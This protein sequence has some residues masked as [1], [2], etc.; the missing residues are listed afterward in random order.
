M[1]IATGP[2]AAWVLGVGHSRDESK[3]D[4]GKE[5]RRAPGDGRRAGVEDGTGEIRLIQQERNKS[6]WKEMGV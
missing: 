3:E 2:Q 5:G 4:Q 6:R 1:L